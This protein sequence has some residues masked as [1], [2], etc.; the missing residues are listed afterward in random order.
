MNLWIPLCH[1]ANLV[2]YTLT[3]DPWIILKQ[4]QDIMSFNL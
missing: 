1:M 4:G 3:L 2:T